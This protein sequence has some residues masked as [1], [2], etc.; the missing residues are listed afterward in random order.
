MEN[1]IVICSTCSC[2]KDFICKSKF[3][4][5]DRNSY[6][7]NNCKDKKSIENKTRTCPNCKKEVI[8]PNP[9]KKKDA[10]RKNSICKNC[11][12]NRIPQKL[13]QEQKQF[14]DG[15]MLG[16]GCIQYGSKGAL[17]P[18]LAVSRQIID[19][20]YLFW[21][22]NVFN[23]FYGTEPKF[24]KRYHNRVKKFY[25]GYSTITKSGKLFL[26]FHSKWYKNG[27]KVIPRDVELTPL[28]MLIWFLDDGCVVKSSK[29]GLTL[30][31]STDGFS[32]KDVKFL[33]DKLSSLLTTK[34]NVYRNGSGFILKASTLAVAALAKIIDPIFPKCMERK[35]TWAGFDFSILGDS[36]MYKNKPRIKKKIINKIRKLYRSKKYN[37]QELANMFS[38]S[39]DSVR[40]YV[41]S[42]ILN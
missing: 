12:S 37:K 34:I 33:A 6:L 28:T 21:Q 17:Y 40:N 8:Y 3:D 19:R 10:D 11:R 32:K 15:L 24:Y 38:V 13:T 25:Y 2:E 7:C 39:K 26:D 41:K 16:D 20:E 36:G 31:I 1:Y 29:S 4:R 30:K 5:V 23:E 35:R 22:Y 9:Q 42:I 27:K 14:L 18:R